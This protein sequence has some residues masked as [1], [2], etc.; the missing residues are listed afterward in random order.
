MKRKRLLPCWIYKKSCGK[1]KSTGRNTDD[2]EKIESSNLFK[3][4]MADNEVYRSE[5][6]IYDSGIDGVVHR[7]SWNCNYKSFS[8]GILLIAG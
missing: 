1:M 5:T 6:S 7:M 4:H 3:N 8:L 2:G